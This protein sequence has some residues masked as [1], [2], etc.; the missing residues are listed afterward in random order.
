MRAGA[1]IIDPYGIGHDLFDVH[2]EWPRCVHRH[3]CIFS[4]L[5]DQ[6]APNPEIS[7]DETAC[8]SVRKL[9]TRGEQPVFS[10]CT[11]HMQK[12]CPC[13][14]RNM[15]PEEQKRSAERRSP[16]GMPQQTTQPIRIPLPSVETFEKRMRRSSHL[17]PGKLR[18]VFRH[19]AEYKEAVS[20]ELKR[21]SQPFSPA[22]LPRSALHRRRSWPCER[23]SPPGRSDTSRHTPCTSAHISD[24]AVRRSRR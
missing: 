5:E 17:A 24:C 7:A 21:S 1:L 13:F 6:A 16:S 9:M 3:C 8:S 12:C 20:C 14:I 15:I 18:P 4:A 11:Q 2:I 23:A 19:A 22:V 10:S